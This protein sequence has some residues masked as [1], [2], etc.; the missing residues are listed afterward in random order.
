[1]LIASKVTILAPSEY[2]LVPVPSFHYKLELTQ[3][4]K[5]SRI[6]RRGFKLYSLSVNPI[7]RKMFLH[8]LDSSSC[9]LCS[10]FFSFYKSPKS[11]ILSVC[12]ELYAIPSESGRGHMVWCVC[13]NML[14]SNSS[15]FNS[16]DHE[17]LKR[18]I[19]AVFS[20]EPDCLYVQY[21]NGISISEVFC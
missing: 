20:G 5:C 8:H 15:L 7:T 4:Y 16:S 14:I 9:V 19:D 13:N 10:I 6:L 3:L 17:T 11:V 21:S 1:M 2:A 18:F 12:W